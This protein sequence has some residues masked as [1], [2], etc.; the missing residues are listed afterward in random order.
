M[1]G[2]AEE[3]K[4]KR[5]VLE[6]KDHPI[7]EKDDFWFLSEQMKCEKINRNSLE[8]KYCLFLELNHSNR[9]K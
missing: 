8:I 9:G 1:L 6:R 2:K 3:L 5:H 7:C 4:L